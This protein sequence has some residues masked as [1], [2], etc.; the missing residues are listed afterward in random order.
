VQTHNITEAK[1]Q[2]SR[3]IEQAQSG[4]Q[5]VIAKAGKPVA[6]LSAWSDEDE[7]RRLSNPW[8][9]K[10]WIADDFDELPDEFMAHFRNDD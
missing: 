5:V 6:V 3:L 4:E 1:A 10:V 7:P 2:L 9:G 8:K